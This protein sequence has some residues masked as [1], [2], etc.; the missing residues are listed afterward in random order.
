[1]RKA[2][3]TKSEI[4][5]ALKRAARKLGRTP[6]RAELAQLTG[7]RYT[8][9]ATLFPGYRA[10]VRAAGLDPDRGGLR[11]ETGAMLCDWGRVAREKG[12]HPT[13][14]EYEKT[15][16]YASASLETRFHRWSKVR[17]SFIKFVEANGLQEEWQDVVESLKTGPIPKRGGGK[18][19][20]KKRTS[21]QIY[22]DE[23]RLEP[24]LPKSP[25]SPGLNSQ[26]RHEQQMELSDAASDKANASA[27]AHA[28]EMNGDPAEGQDAGTG[29]LWPPLRGMKKVTKTMLWM[30]AGMGCGA[31][32]ECGA[33]SLHFPKRVLPGRPLMGARVSLES[34][35]HEPV[36]EMGVVFLFGMV[37]HRLGFVVEALQSGF[38][39]CEAKLEVEPGRWQ[40]VRIEFEY[41]SRK[42]REHRHDTSQC[43]MIVCWMH[44]WPG[45]PAG[46]QV[47]ELRRVFAADLRG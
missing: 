33:R 7:I 23:G 18:S 29:E 26:Q 28:R 19:W 8:Q 10:A 40:H 22:A 46:I 24:S 9:M 25:D 47:L 35:A 31:R 21:P 38:P 6:T 14:D 27:A 11:I 30:L 42:F 41:E 36:N 12:R 4:I 20:L 45:C 17:E 44:N 43:D 15:G 3:L 32:E 1:M 39:D 16:R 5:A 2:S 37:A 13:R 34:P